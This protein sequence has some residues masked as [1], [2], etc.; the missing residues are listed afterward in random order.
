MYQYKA[1]LKSTK[2]IIAKGHTLEDIEKEIV[3]FIREQK[4]GIHT[5]SNVPIEVYHIQRNKTDGTNLSKEK[6]VKT[7]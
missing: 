5:N 4:K 6:L 1:V 2:E 7:I 3:H